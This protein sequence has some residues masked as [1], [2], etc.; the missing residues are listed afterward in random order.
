SIVI[1]GNFF[2]YLFVSFLYMRIYSLLLL[3]VAVATVFVII[4]LL[5][6]N[7][8]YVT[9]MIGSKWIEA[10]LG[11]AVVALAYPL[12]QNRN[13]LKQLLLLILLGTFTGALTGIV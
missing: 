1:F 2:A 3:Q 13:V 8:S 4:A 11:P 5:L 7:V 12:Y 6:F 9:Y 10:F